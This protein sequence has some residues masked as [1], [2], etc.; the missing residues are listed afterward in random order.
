MNTCIFSPCA[1]YRYTLETRASLNPA[2]KTRIV[3]VM[4]NPSTANEHHLDPTLLRCRAFANRWG[5]GVM[6]VVNLFAFRT[7]HP[8]E[9]KA[10]ADPIGPDNDR[11]IRE[12]IQRANMTLIAWGNH[13]AYRDRAAETLVNVDNWSRQIFYCLGKTKN[14]SPIHPLARGKMRVPDTA[15]PI[16]WEV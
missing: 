1:L 2:N 12:Q 11:H 13:G 3:F 9:M 10:T 14:G 15:K 6:V 5:F 4:L 7:P 8:D 16:R